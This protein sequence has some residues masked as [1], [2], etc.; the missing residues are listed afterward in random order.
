MTQNAPQHTQTHRAS[1]W[2][3]IFSEIVGDHFIIIYNPV[4]FSII[5]QLKISNLFRKLN[6]ILRK[7]KLHPKLKCSQNFKFLKSVILQNNTDSRAGEVCAISGG[8]LFVC[9]YCSMLDLIIDFLFRCLLT[10]HFITLLEVVP[11]I[12]TET[13]LLNSTSMSGFLMMK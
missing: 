5:S 13:V 10:C 7:A 8:V 1:A 11:I 3:F 12:S 4:H 9:C 2:V 6:K